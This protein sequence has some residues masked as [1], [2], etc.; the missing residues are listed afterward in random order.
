MSDPPT[1]RTTE[2]QWRGGPTTAADPA[3]APLLNVWFG[4]LFIRRGQQ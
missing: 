4:R 2:P 1:V 3:S